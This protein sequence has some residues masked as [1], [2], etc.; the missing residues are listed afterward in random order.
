MQSKRFALRIYVD[1]EG[2]VGVELNALDQSDPETD[3]IS[4][5]EGGLVKLLECQIITQLVRAENNVDHAL[6]LLGSSV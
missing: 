1:G 3:N 5:V 6:D 2:H 4:Q